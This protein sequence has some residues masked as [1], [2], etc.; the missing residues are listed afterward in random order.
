M[1]TQKILLMKHSFGLFLI[2]VFLALFGCAQKFNVET[3]KQAL[4]KLSGEDWDMYAR[5]GNIE[6]MV[7]SYTDDAL[8][9]GEGAILRGKEEIR[10]YLTFLTQ[11]S[12]PE[13]L[14][15]K[16]E[17]IKISGDLAVVRG[18][19]EGVFT[20]KEEGEKIIEKGVWVDVCER[21]ENGTWKMVLT[22]ASDMGEGNKQVAALYHELNPDD[23]D[24]ILTEDFIGRNE[25]SRM[26]WT[27]EQHY[28]YWI[29]NRGAMKDKIF[30]QVAEGDWVATW[31]ARTGEWEG[32]MV[33]FEMMH[34]K[35]FEDG[36][37]AE[38][39]EYGDSQQLETE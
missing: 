11:S 38:I 26:T 24:A 19:F 28:N 13:K 7:E 33:T 3:D 36:K 27:K 29:N 22:L 14:E 25:K 39:W 8:R 9:I 1:Q 16:V 21:Q 4:E 37:I 17:D 32:E 15:N 18:S 12:T 20:P 23:M 10:S 34:F 5:A 35:R 2:I 30:H 31:F 6:G